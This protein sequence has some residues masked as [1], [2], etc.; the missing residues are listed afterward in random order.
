MP[1]NITNYYTPDSAFIL[2]TKENAEER[3]QEIAVAGAQSG[4]LLA[5]E[6]KAELGAYVRA[7][8]NAY[9]TTAA[10][11]HSGA[12]GAHTGS[13]IGFDLDHDA[14]FFRD[15]DN[16]RTVRILPET[17]SLD[18]AEVRNADEI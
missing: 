8:I 18:D 6:E 11:R 3:M 15:G 2:Q 13:V 14:K 17:A 9:S 5:D 4:E 12:S 10:R 7:M 1:Q 16:P